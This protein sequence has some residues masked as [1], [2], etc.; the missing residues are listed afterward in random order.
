MA[1]N[2]CGD[3]CGQCGGPCN[4]NSRIAATPKGCTR[5]GGTKWISELVDFAMPHG[6]KQMPCPVCSVGGN[7]TR[8]DYAAGAAFAEAQQRTADLV[9]NK[10]EM[11]EYAK[12]AHE[13]LHKLAKAVGVWPPMNS[14]HE[15]YG[16]LLEEVQELFDEVRLK[17]SKRTVEAMRAECLDV[18]AMAIRMA[19]EVCNEPVIRR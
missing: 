10:P 15:G 4:G 18:A 11:R 13:M 1:C 3:D 6:S 14:A 17:Q 7:R 5:C 2:I 16:V 19:V 9:D 12:A 8:E